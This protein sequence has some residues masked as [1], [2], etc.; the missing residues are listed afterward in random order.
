VALTTLS[1]CANSAGLEFNRILGGTHGWPGGTVEPGSVAPMSDL[2]A[3]LE[4]WKFFAK[5]TRN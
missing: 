4:M 3:S 5:H 1:G 2:R